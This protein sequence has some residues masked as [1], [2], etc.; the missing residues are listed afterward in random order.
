[1]KP[2]LVVTEPFGSYQRGD[3]ISDAATMQSILAS[4]NAGHV[5]RTNVPDDIKPEPESTGKS[6][7]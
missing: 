5:V 2:V 3:Q 6:K 7:K 1:M 4:E